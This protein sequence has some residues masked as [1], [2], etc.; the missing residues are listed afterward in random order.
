MIK[1]GMMAMWGRRL[2]GGGLDDLGDMI[3][4][5]SNRK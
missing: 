4:L 5:G 1:M 3:M 2:G